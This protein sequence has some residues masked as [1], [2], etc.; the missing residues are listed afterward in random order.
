MA[1]SVD[2]DQTATHLLH[3]EVWS[4]FTLFDKDY[5]P[6]YLEEAL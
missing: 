6:E 1:N 4:G 3:E 5:M 2:P